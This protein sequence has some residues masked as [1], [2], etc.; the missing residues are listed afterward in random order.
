MSKLFYLIRHCHPAGQTPNAPL[1]P[2]GC[3]QAEALADFLAGAEIERIVSS[4]YERAR[5]SIAPLAERLGIGIETDARLCE[6]VL[7]PVP[8]ADWRDRLRESFEDLDLCLAGGESSRTAMQR[9]VAVVD[10]VR[11]HP[12]RSIALVTHGNLLTLLLR[13]FDGRSGFDTWCK[14]TYPDVFRV[15][16]GKRGAQ[17]ERV[18]RE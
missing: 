6:R 3:T 5:Q 16:F 14:L 15:L 2:E 10:E 4:P 13:R 12:A 7:S 18:W 11:R 9:A 17:V 8:R 1:T